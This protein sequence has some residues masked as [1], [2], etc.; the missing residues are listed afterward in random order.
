MTYVAGRGGVKWNVQSG[1]SA[2]P[3]DHLGML[4]GGVV[5]ED[6]VD[7]HAG[8]DLALDGVQEADE[9]LMPVAPHAAADDFAFQH[10]EG[11]EQGGRAMSHVVVGHGPGPALLQG[12]I[13]LGAIQGL[14]LRLLIDAEDDG[15]GRRIDIESGDARTL[16][17][18]L[19]SLDSLKV[20]MRCG[21]KPWTRQMRCSEVR[22][23]RATLAI[24]RPVQ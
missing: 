6:G 23:T 24:T 11:G 15:V 9:L 5:V 19:G 12:Q 14:D 16:A 1:V 10:V 3:F 21:A 4:V 22:L 7:G 2:Q 17:A 18:K 13:W 8:R 20:R